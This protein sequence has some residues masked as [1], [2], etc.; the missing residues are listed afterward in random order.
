[1]SETR[2]ING[3]VGYGTVLRQGVNGEWQRVW[4]NCETATD[5]GI[6]PSLDI[7]RNG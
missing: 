1:M 7:Y 6:M 3:K 2:D 4:G 5:D